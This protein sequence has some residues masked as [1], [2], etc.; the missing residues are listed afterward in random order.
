MAAITTALRASGTDNPDH[1]KI[2]G[3]LCCC[4]LS[5]HTMPLRFLLVL[6]L[7]GA[8]HTPL[9]IIYNIIYNC[10]CCRPFHRFHTSLI[11]VILLSATKEITVGG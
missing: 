4:F 7:F 1:L 10:G 6:N 5:T 8:L 11:Y 2:I 3:L 9:L